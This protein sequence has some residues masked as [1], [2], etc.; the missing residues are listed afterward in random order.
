M[1]IYHVI[2]FFCSVFQSKLYFKPPFYKLGSTISAAEDVLSCS[3]FLNSSVFQKVHVC[4]ADYFSYLIRDFISSFCHWI[5]CHYSILNFNLLYIQVCAVLYL[6]P[7]WKFPR[8]QL[9]SSNTQNPVFRH[10]NLT[11]LILFLIF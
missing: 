6:F 9:S 1:Q 7:F 2:F 4:E 8:T 5:R 10:R 3:L 11:W